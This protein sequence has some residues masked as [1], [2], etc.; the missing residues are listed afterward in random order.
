MW[1]T[2]TMW[3]ATFMRRGKMERELR[4][5]VLRL[6][7]SLLGYLLFLFFLIGGII[8]LMIHSW[9][10]S[11]IFLGISLS[12]FLL[13]TYVYLG[14]SLYVI[15]D[16]SVYVPRLWRHAKDKILELKNVKKVK[17]VQGFF[18][19]GYYL[20]TSDGYYY[21]KKSV[22]AE[23]REHLPEGCVFVEE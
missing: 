3:P 13:T 5:K 14:T 10:T 20:Y 17:P 8:N 12:L 16:H 9:L 22:F 7:F 23:I 2:I 19:D 6:T 11:L 1:A 18:K 21:L 15:F 4:F